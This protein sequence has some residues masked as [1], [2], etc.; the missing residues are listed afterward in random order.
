M[1]TDFDPYE[2]ILEEEPVLDSDLFVAVLDR[3]P[4]CR[5]HIL[6]LAKNKVPSLSDCASY[7]AIQC[8]IERLSQKVFQGKTG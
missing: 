2:R 4:I 5:D 3:E 1:K 7:G 6:V 8:F